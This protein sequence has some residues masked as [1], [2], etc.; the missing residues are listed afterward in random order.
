MQNTNP[1]HHATYEAKSYA[2]AQ[3]QKLRAKS[4]RAVVWTIK[5]K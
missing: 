3:L 5:N 2:E 4:K 1:T